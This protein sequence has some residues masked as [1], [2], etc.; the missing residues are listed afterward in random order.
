[1][2]FNLRPRCIQ[3]LNLKKTMLPWEVSTVT[4]RPSFLF[5]SVLFNWCGLF[6]SYTYPWGCFH[7]L[8]VCLLWRRG[9]GFLMTCTSS[10]YHTWKYLCSGLVR[11]TAIA[12]VHKG[13][14][15]DC[16][17]CSRAHHSEPCAFEEL[18]RQSQDTAS[19]SE[20]HKH[21]PLLFTR[22][23]EVI[24]CLVILSNEAFTLVTWFPNIWEMCES[25]K[26]T[27][28]MKFRWFTWCF[29]WKSCSP[30]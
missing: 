30:L 4:T 22:S 2:N 28:C 17:W 5:N 7:F 29:N 14:L 11:A 13:A 23:H 26:L 10:K 6:C 20:N 27:A 21:T 9:E 12:T 19:T 8:Y 15:R 1:M 3:K 24:Y 16:E 18:E 25:Q